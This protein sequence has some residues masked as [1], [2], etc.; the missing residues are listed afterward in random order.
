MDQHPRGER[1]YETYVEGLEKSHLPLSKRSSALGPRRTF[2]RGTSS[3]EEGIGSRARVHL[4]RLY[5]SKLC[6][7]LTQRSAVRTVFF[8]EVCVFQA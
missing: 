3:L 7:A 2:L 4:A 1:D 8:E 5:F 6:L